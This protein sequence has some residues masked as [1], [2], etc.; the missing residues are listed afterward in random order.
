[1]QKKSAAAATGSI[2]T[3]PG[4]QMEIPVE[5]YLMAGS[6]EVDGNGPNTRGRRK[7]FRVGRGPRLTIAA[8]VLLSL[9]MVCVP[10]A[11]RNI[12]R[13]I[14]RQL[15]AKRAGVK[16]A[17]IIVLTIDADGM[18]VLEAADLVHRGVSNQVARSSMTSR[19]RS[20]SS[21][22]VEAFPV[23]IWLLCPRGELHSLGVQDVEQIPRRTSGSEQEG[24]IPA[25]LV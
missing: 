15:V 21:F 2:L 4:M 3:P 20:I 19:A 12:L 13:A 16:S 23:R 14:G 7:W 11:R 10:G 18:G 8:L 25:R 5:R 9:L 24:E 1:M 17:D 22:S 6:I